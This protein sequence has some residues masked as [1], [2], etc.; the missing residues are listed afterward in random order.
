MVGPA[1]GTSPRPDFWKKQP[2]RV[3]WQSM[4]NEGSNH[5]LGELFEVVTAG[6]DGEIGLMSIRRPQ[7]APKAP[8][9]GANAVSG[10][11]I[12]RPRHGKSPTGRADVGPGAVRNGTFFKVFW[13]EA[14]CYLDGEKGHDTYRGISPPPLAMLELRDG[15]K[16]ISVTAR[17][18]R[19]E[20]SIIAR[21]A[22]SWPGNFVR[23]NC[24]IVSI[25]AQRCGAA[26]HLEPR[27][28]RR[29]WVGW[30]D[31]R[32]LLH[33]FMG[34]VYR[35]ANA[36]YCRRMR[37][38]DCVGH[39][40]HACHRILLRANHQCPACSAFGHVQAGAFPPRE[41]AAGAGRRSFGPAHRPVE[42]LPPWKQP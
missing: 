25:P 19:A 1:A 9:V 5:Q 35:K 26:R 12:L 13:S 21:Q 27:Q 6:G 20:C 42:R 3:T 7:L 8:P 17:R 41:R 14:A 4:L 22:K 16:P 2:S 23:P 24:R 18:F 10:H 38:P 34:H 15:R 40:V 29:D 28:H 37:C 33:N 31:K 36:S 11:H 32:G 39:H 30:L